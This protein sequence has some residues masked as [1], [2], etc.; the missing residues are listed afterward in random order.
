MLIRSGP[1]AV[2]G[3]DIP[4]LKSDRIQLLNRIITNGMAEVSANYHVRGEI[5]QGSDSAEIRM[6]RTVGRGLGGMKRD[7]YY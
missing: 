1:R 5:M 4:F 3:D 7:S 6:T 2:S